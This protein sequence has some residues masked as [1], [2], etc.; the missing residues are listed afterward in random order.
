MAY[1]NTCAYCGA[2]LDPGGGSVI[3]TRLHM[4]MRSEKED[5]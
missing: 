2:N 3:V 5:C 1:Y 4:V